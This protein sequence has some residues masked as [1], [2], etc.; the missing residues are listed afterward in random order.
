MAPK[1]P[2]R[3]V[4]DIDLREMAARVIH[5]KPIAVRWIPGHRQLSDARDAHQHTNIMRN[6]EVDRLAKLATTLPLPIFTPT[7][8]A[9]ISVGGTKAPTPAKKW[10]AA[11]PPYP[12]HLGAHRER[13]LRAVGAPQAPQGLRNLFYCRLF[14]KQTR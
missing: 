4:S 10:I 12:T 5:Q 8:P 3:E 13:F 7:S 9:S 6:N 2:H 1:P 11:L 14:R